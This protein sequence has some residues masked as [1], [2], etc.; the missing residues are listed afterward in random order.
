MAKLKVRKSIRWLQA[1][2]FG[3]VCVCVARRSISTSS[4]RARVVYDGL[5]LEYPRRASSVGLTWGRCVARALQSP[6]M[7][8]VQGGRNDSCVS[9]PRSRFQVMAGVRCLRVVCSRRT[10]ASRA[11]TPGC[12]VSSDYL[13]M[14]NGG[15]VVVR[16]VYCVAA[17][18]CPGALCSR[19]AAWR[20]DC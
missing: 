6:R 5:S 14:L 7:R 17:D 4:S 15:P 16:V 8:A 10:P 19:N 20:I 2:L 1:K 3:R 12:S 11:C 13:C 9:G 18:R